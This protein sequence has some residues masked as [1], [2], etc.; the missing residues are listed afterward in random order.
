MSASKASGATR[1]RRK[2]AVGTGVT[3][4]VLS[5]LSVGVVTYTA[6]AEETHTVAQPQPAAVNQPDMVHQPM[7]LCHGTAFGYLGRWGRSASCNFTSPARGWHGKLRI[8]W[9]TQEGTNQYACVEA[10]MTNRGGWASLGCGKSGVGQIAW[11]ANTMGQFE[12]RAKAMNSIFA[13]A[14]FGI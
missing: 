2:I 9:H 11:P 1:R 7:A 4:A 13:A 10:R 8:N 3:L 14:D 12:V 6:G 5:A